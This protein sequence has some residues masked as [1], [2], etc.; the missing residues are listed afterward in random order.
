MESGISLVELTR[1]EKLYAWPVLRPFVE[2]ALAYANGD[3]NA[4]DVW[5]RCVNQMMQIWVACEGGK[6]WAVGVTEIINYP[7]TRVLRLV[8]LSGENFNL[9]KHFEADLEKFAHDHECHYIDAIGRRGLVKLG[10]EFGFREVATGIRK[11]VSRS[12]H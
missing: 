6:I 10:K 1:A 4:E 2:K 9:W 7:Q 12:Y 3:I 8:A 11:T 5:V